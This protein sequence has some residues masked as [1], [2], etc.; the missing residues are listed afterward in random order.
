[1]RFERE[2]NAEPLTPKFVRFLHEALGGID[3]DELQSAEA[4]RV[5]YV[6][7]NGLVAVEI[8]TLETDGHERIENLTEN[9]R[10]REDWPEFYGAWPM[11]S[12]LS[13]LTDKDIVRR[14]FEERIGRSIEDHLRKAKGQLAAHAANFP[15]KNLVRIV[16]VI[17]ENHILYDPENVAHI[18]HNILRSSADGAPRYSDI[19]CVL[20]FTE[21]H[22]GLLNKNLTFPLLQIDGPKLDEEPWKLVVIERIIS[23]W[24]RWRG[25]SLHFGE[26]GEHRFEPIDQIPDTMSRQEAWELSYRRNRYLAPMTNEQLR[27]RYDEVICISLLA[28]T[29]NSPFKPPKQAIDAAMAGMCHLQQEMGLRAIPITEFRFKHTRVLQAAKR[30]GLHRPV[31]EWFES[32]LGREVIH[33]RNKS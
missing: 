6:C 13:H 7:L 4:R 24:A 11:D 14:K 26:F 1:M 12:V 3:Q 27:E 33:S 28:F 19:D 15:R 9:L 20:Y 31:I 29:K 5:D 8:K 32:N 16:V 21:R 17:N 10:K 23:S 30:L 18:T 2:G 22:A 25:R